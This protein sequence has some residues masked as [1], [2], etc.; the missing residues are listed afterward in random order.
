MLRSVVVKVGFTEPQGR[1]LEMIGALRSF[2]VEEVHIVHVHEGADRPLAEKRRKALDALRAEAEGLG[3]KAE[4]HVFTGPPARRLLDAAEHLD[5]DCVCVA[6][7]HKAVLRQ[8]LLGS[9]DGDILRLSDIPVFLFK[10]GFLSPTETL[11]SVLYATDFQVT[12]TKVMP[13]LKNKDF[14][15]RVLYLLNVRERAPD[16][17]TDKARSEEVMENLGRL[18]SECAHAYDEV[19]PMETVGTTRRQI[20]RQAKSLGVDLVVV[21]KSDSPDVLSKLTGSTAEYLPHRAP[22]SIFIVPGHR[23]RGG[24]R[25]ESR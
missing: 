18:A 21:G 6:W 22:C 19:Q 14:Q 1:V 25:E 15:A 20:V 9:I 10:R 13:Y 17:A 8:A 12:D 24:R 3:L 23:D 11:D 16:P 4:T 2:G 7:V 5:A